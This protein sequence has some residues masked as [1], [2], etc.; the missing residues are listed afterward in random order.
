VEEPIRLL[1]DKAI[2]VKPTGNFHL[3]RDPDNDPILE[4]ALLGQA[5][6]MASRMMISS[7]I[8]SS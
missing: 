8:L 4:I 2:W 5:E 7:E 1:T 3:C 6:Q